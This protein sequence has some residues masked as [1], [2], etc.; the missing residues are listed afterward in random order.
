MDKQIENIIRSVVPF[1]TEISEYQYS[2]PD[3][4]AM[5]GIQK[6]HL[7]KAR[8]VLSRAV[9]V[10]KSSTMNTVIFAQLG[11][12]EDELGAYF[13][14]LADYFPGSN[15]KEL[16]IPRDIEIT[17]TDVGNAEL[18]GIKLKANH[19]PVQML[20]E[21]ESSQYGKADL[22][23]LQSAN[24]AGLYMLLFLAWIIM[25]SDKWPD[26]DFDRYHW[27]P[28]MMGGATFEPSF[29]DLETAIRRF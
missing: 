26:G 19:D 27:V 10:A 1:V 29:I 25:L 20:L 2:V 28:E 14:D 7:K 8:S 9:D 24:P 3:E 12:L 15:L 5:T 22:N 4:L 11:Y 18:M 16:S 6:K 13:Y 23:N 21:G 17:F